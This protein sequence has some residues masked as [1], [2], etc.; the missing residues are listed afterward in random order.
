MWEHLNGAGR[1]NLILG[2][3]YLLGA[4][5]LLIVM[6]TVDLGP[7]LFSSSFVLLVVLGVSGA[8]LLCLVGKK[9]FM[10]IGILERV[11]EM[12]RIAAAT[13]LAQRNQGIDMMSSPEAVGLPIPIYRCD[14]CG[15]AN[16]RNTADKMYWVN[17]QS[18]LSA[19]WY[20]EDCVDKLEDK[21]R[22]ER[23]NLEIFLVRLNG[24][25]GAD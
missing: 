16:V 1:Y 12:R 24:D 23:L 17:E 6:L 22:Y 2:T 25:S 5:A 21:P 20:C 13:D 9:A 8:L 7:E 14:G 18:L 4:F 10:K 15:S 3:T 11:R 19:G